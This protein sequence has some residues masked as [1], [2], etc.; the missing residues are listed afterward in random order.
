MGTNLFTHT[1]KFCLGRWLFLFPFPGFH[2]QQHVPSAFSK[3]QLTLLVLL[4]QA[5]LG[6]DD[7]VAPHCR[8]GSMVLQQQLTKTDSLEALMWLL[9]SLQLLLT[10]TSPAV[11]VST[12]SPG[13]NS[14]SYTGIPPSPSSPLFNTSR[15]ILVVTQNGPS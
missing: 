6:P 11:S 13:L 14:I 15:N 1:C 3:G 12:T 10:E 7:I 2:S 9:L 8:P 5:L 4:P